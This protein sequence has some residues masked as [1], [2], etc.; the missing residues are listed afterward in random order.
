MIGRLFIV[1][2]P[3]G[4]GKDT[5]LKI[6]LKNNPDIFFS[7]SSITRE[8]RN[9]DEKEKYNFISREEFVSMIESDSLLE[10]N[11]YCGNY[12]GTPKAPIADAINNGTDVIVE[13]DVNGKN[14]I[15]KKAD[16]AVTVF[17]MPP[18]IEVLKNRLSGRGTESAEVVEKRMAEAIR[19]IKQAHNYDYVVVN[20]KLEEAV[21]D[22]QHII[23][24]DKLKTERNINFLEEVLKNA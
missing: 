10:Y 21:A 13:V 15:C 2:G 24:A 9:P 6:L 17:I 23:D 19:E 8:M 16:N 3:S 22:L 18:S 12:Y 7:I 4:S 20:D 11:E 5:I 1:S 14:N